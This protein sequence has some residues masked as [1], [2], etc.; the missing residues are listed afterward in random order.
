MIFTID[1]ENKISAFATAE[2]AAA[3]TINQMRPA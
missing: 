1:A 3:A 2:E